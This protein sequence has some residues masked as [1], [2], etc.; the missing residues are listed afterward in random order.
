MNAEEIFNQ[1]YSEIDG[2][3]VSNAA[4]KTAGIEEGLLYGELPFAT[5]QAIVERTNPKKDGVFFDLGSGTGRIIIQSSL[6]FDFKKLVG[7]E[8]LQGLHDKA[9][10]TQQKLLQIADAPRREISFI[11]ASILDID[12]R[13]ADFIFMNH[14]L[15]DR[16]MF[17]KIEEKFLS[18]LKPGTKIT[19]TIRALENP[20]FKSLGNQK[21][22]FS[23]GE[24]TAY[25]FEV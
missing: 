18:E 13:E 16:E 9:C 12:L 4:R 2:Y 10:E 22:N 20:G 24:S 19:T 23:W 8:L 17:A 15:K 25:F 5:W 7:V 14:P 6:L 1:L 21:Y 3:A 11:N